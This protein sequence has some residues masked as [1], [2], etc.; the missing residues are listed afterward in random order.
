MYLLTVFTGLANLFFG[1]ICIGLLDLDKLGI[2][3]SNYRIS[4]TSKEKR[5]VCFYKTFLTPFYNLTLQFLIIT[6]GQKYF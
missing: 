5:P 6:L 4:H 3:K 2:V 1:H